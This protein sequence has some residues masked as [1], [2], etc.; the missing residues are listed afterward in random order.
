M[1][2]HFR[3]TARPPK[4]GDR[5]RRGIVWGTCGFYDEI[6]IEFAWLQRDSGAHGFG[7][8][9]Y[10]KHRTCMQAIEVIQA[11]RRRSQE[12]HKKFVE[13]KLMSDRLT[14]PGSIGQRNEEIDLGEDECLAGGEMKS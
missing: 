11:I 6:T 5:V 3:S 9:D 7:C 10:R 12:S 8:R 13:V 2:W 4:L 14:A 1:S